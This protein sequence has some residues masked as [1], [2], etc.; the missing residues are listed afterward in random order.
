M[1]A[2]A[3]PLTL[4]ALG[5]VA[6]YVEGGGLG[7]T[8]GRPRPAVCGCALQ[9]AAF[10][11]AEAGARPERLQ[12][13]TEAYP[14]LASGVLT[15]ARLGDLPKGVLVQ[16]GQ[17]EWEMTRAD[18]DRILSQM[19][20]HLADEARQN[21]FFLIENEATRPLLLLA[22]REQTGADRPQDQGGAPPDHEVIASYLEGV[23]KDVQ[24]ADEEV[25]AFHASNTALLGGA[26]LDEVKDQIRAFLLDEKRNQRIDDHI[27]DLGGKMDVVV[28]VT[29]AKQQAA[30]AG[31][32]PVNRARSGDQVALVAFSGSGCCGPDR[33]QPLLDT[34]R[35]RWPERLAVVY[36]EA[37]RQPILAARYRV[38]SIPTLLV[39]E[40]GGKEVA[41]W[42]GEVGWKDLQGA[43]ERA[44][45]Q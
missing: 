9:Q 27:T 18:L 44:G 1:K 29:W 4:V 14:Q 39:Y 30:L 41:R 35:R 34:A 24:V 5:L 8:V 20:P 33:V 2:L 15:R 19:P 26:A 6:L 32:N 17:W 38:R 36:I 40:K 16:R 22:A 12:T 21:A 3:I 23:T 7:D 42:Q 28:D 31:D 25:R 10:A 37:Q 43:L 13:V 11:A 45:V